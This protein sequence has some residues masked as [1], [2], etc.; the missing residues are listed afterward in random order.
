MRWHALRIPAIRS[1]VVNVHFVASR[2]YDKCWTVLPL[3]DLPYF[4]S[5]TASPFFFESIIYLF[6]HCPDIGFCLLQVLIKVVEINP[7]R[8]CFH[9]ESSRCSLLSCWRYVCC[10]LV[11]YGHDLPI[12]GD[13]P[14][15]RHLEVEAALI[16][17]T[18]I[19]IWDR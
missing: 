9:S 7:L 1:V 4:N 17:E 12:V 3:S 5:P 13:P 19:G 8:Y 14:H 10:Q 15:L 11:H 18:T 2:R 16:W 6:Y